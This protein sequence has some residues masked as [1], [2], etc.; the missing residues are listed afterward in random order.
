M[1]TTHKT[2]LLHHSI[3]GLDIHKGD[4]V[5]GTLGGG[6]HS[7]EIARRFGGDVV[8]IGIDMDKK[9][10]ERSEERISKITPHALFFQ[11]NFRN[12]DKVLEKA[13]KTH[14]DRILLDIGLSSDQ[15]EVSGR[16]FSFRK[17]EPLLMTFADDP[18]E[19]Q[20]TAWT[21][22]NEW[23]EESIADIIYGYG[24]ERFSRRIAR[25]IVE[26]R[27]QKPINTT[28]ELVQVIESSVPFFYRKGKI[29]PATKTFQ[30]LRIAVNDELGALK[31][32]LKKGVELLNS[33]GRMA[34]ISF[35]SLE[36]RIVKHYFREL[37][38]EGKVLVI[39]K[40]A[41]VPNEE[42]IALNPRSRSSKLRIIEKI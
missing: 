39:T 4:V 5:D 41:I 26:E 10:L 12:I 15:F 3:D 21:I 28:F 2:V 32:A 30:A 42:E 6:G 9:A 25:R 14:A 20:F 19:H 1:T 22:V 38:Q 37:E 13:G 24:E 18:N 17:N 8:L 23:A 36:D 31:E 35:H 27:A 33:K 40:R 11:D 7:E 29:H 34:V 16:G